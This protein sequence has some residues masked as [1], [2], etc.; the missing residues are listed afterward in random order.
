MADILSSSAALC[1]DKGEICAVIFTA[2]NI[3][4][5]L[6]LERQLQRA[7]RM[8]AVWQLIGSIVQDLNNLH[9]VVVGNL[10]LIIETTREGEKRD[11]VHAVMEGALRS[12]D[13]V[14]RLPAF[15]RMQPLKPK[16]IDLNE[17]LPSLNALM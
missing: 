10:D 13:L 6:L 7:Q 1:D 2:R 8:E 15:A 3:T 16:A 4:D 9:G 17:C 11:P 12:S 5:R 14:Q